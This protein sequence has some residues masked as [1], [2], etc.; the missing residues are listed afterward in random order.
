MQRDRSS[1]SA[2]KTGRVPVYLGRDPVLANLLPAGSRKSAEAILLAAKGL[3]RWQLMLFDQAWFRRWLAWMERQTAT[4]ISLH[5]ALRKRFFDDEVR[6]AIAEG[7]EQILVLGAG[8]DTLC[9]RLSA[10][11]PELRFVELDHPATARRKAKAVAALKIRR[12]NLRLIAA[13]LE[14][15]RL[16]TVLQTI[17]GWDPTARQAIV[18]E[19]L[20]MYL[21]PASV[22]RLFAS[23]RTNA[24]EGSVFLFSYLPANP[25]GSLNLGTRSSLLELGM[26]FSGETMRWGLAPGDVEN[27]IEQQGFRVNPDAKRVD[28]RERYLRPAGLDDQALSPT[29][30]LAIA[31]I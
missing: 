27:W 5:V 30:N 28:L 29:E 17:P 14:R 4:G 25:D 8:Y 21:R 23:V 9:L 2:L 26:R 31:H 16:S 20:L 19:G 15:E 13:D 12:P 11:F 3:Y 7:A 24:P 18:A 10:A 6:R 22:T 1:L